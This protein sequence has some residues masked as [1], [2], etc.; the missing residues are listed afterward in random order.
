MFGMLI[1][2]IKIVGCIT[3][4]LDLGDETCDLVCIPTCPCLQKLDHPRSGIIVTT[5]NAAVIPVLEESCKKFVRQAEMCKINEP[6]PRVSALIEGHI[7]LG[8]D[9]AAMEILWILVSGRRKSSARR[10]ARG[11]IKNE[12][13]D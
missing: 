5:S 4:T 11:G 10:E 2:V 12:C 13:G 8:F 7:M 1:A 9:S 6:L 3:R